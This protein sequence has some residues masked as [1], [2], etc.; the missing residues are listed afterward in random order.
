M[1][2][3]VPNLIEGTTT[4][5]NISFELDGKPVGHYTHSP[6]TISLYE[7]NVTVYSHSELENVQHI[8]KMYAEGDE[9]ASLFLFDWAEYT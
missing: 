1:Y 8:L 9:G 7:Y 4:F 5:V 2:C 3:I 6:D